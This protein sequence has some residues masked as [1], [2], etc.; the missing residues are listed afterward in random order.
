MNAED[1]ICIN[2]KSPS[3]YLDGIY[4]KIEVPYNS[5][6][7]NKYYKNDN[8]KKYDNTHSNSYSNIVVQSLDKNSNIDIKRKSKLNIKTNPKTSKYN[9]RAINNTDKYS[10]NN[11]KYSINNDKYSINNDKYSTNT[12]TQAKNIKNSNINNHELYKKNKLIVK[13]NRYSIEQQ[14]IYSCLKDMDDEIHTIL[15]RNNYYNKNIKKYFNFTNKNTC[16]LYFNDDLSDIIKKCIAKSYNNKQ[17]IKIQLKLRDVF[18]IE[19][20]KPIFEIINIS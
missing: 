17:N 7:T 3:F 18:I 6:T 1:H 4:I 15:K 20:F 19:G 2:Y 10:T 16:E 12:V 14:E 9:N 8:I 5:I 11:D 13:F